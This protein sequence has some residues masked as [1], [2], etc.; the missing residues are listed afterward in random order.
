MSETAIAQWNPNTNQQRVLAVDQQRLQFVADLATSASDPGAL[1]AIS[2]R[3]QRFFLRTLNKND[4]NTRIMRIETY[5]TRPVMRNQYTPYQFTPGM[6]NPVG[7]TP[8][9]TTPTAMSKPYFSGI[10]QPYQYEPVGIAN[11]ANKNPFTP[12]NTG[13]LPSR[14]PILTLAPTT[15]RFPKLNPTYQDFNTI[16]FTKSIPR[17]I[18][19]LY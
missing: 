5:A 10:S 12:I 7:Y 19:S 1:Y 11:R 15:Y 6:T 13:G 4:I 16:R 9:L 8:A 18:T 14:R 3:F 2:S 17:N